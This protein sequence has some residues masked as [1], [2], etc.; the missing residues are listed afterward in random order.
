MPELAEVEYFRKEWEPGC[1]G[2]VRGVA[3]HET[4]RLFRRCDPGELGHWLPGATLVG[5]EAHGKRMLFRFKGHDG[6][7]L[8]LGL[9]LGMTGKLYAAEPERSAE[10]HEHLIL[11]QE[12]R[13]LVFAD[14]RQFGRVEFARGEET[15]VWWRNLPPQILSDDFTRAH[16]D[17]FLERHPG[18]AIK[19]VLLMQKGFPGLGNWMVDEILF[20][21]GVHPAR[22]AGRLS[23]REGTRLWE[24]VR[25]VSR[26]AM[27]T[28]GKD[29][30][31][32]PED[33][34]FHRRWKRGGIC[35]R[36]GGTLQYETIAGRTTCW[37]RRVQH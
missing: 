3:L 31:D 37:S 16:F 19:A 26:T 32:P 35:P 11:H 20:R 22:P 36:T 21:A 7:R 17:R 1:G 8:W 14:S 12:A 24:E 27:N 29:F 13:S 9:H 6:M 15:P 5:S 30:R 10:K 28:V 18:P 4:T 23:R 2:V 25:S 33:W 34:L